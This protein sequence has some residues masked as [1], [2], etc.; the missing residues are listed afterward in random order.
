MNNYIQCGDCDWIGTL[1]E[2]LARRIEEHDGLPPPYRVSISNACPS[3]ETEDDFN[4]VIVCPSCL[5]EG[6]L[7][8]VDVEDGDLCHECAAEEYA[9][10]AEA[11]ADHREDR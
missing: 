1:E 2:T 5:E 8:V 6:V 11:K 7:K 3:C 10:Q 9:S 4:D